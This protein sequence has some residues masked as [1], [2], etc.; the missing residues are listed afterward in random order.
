MNLMD[1][2]QQVDDRLKL[3][4]VADEQALQAVLDGEVAAGPRLQGV[5]SDVEPRVVLAATLYEIELE[6]RML[7]ER[8]H[9]QFDVVAKTEVR[10][11][12]TTQQAQ[13]TP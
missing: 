5:A 6:C 13:D 7:L 11:L 4:V 1:L 9:V 10:I 3:L 12:P 2:L 8:L